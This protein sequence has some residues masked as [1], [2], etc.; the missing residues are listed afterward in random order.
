[1][2]T[3]NIIIERRLEWILEDIVKKMNNN[4]LI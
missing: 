3:I 4:C 2:M 1:M